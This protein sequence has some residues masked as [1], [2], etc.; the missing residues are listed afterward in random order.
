MSSLAHQSVQGCLRRLYPYMQEIEYPFLNSILL[1]LQVYGEH[2]IL[3]SIKS[4]QIRPDTLT[5]LISLA[6]PIKLTLIHVQSDI[7]H[8]DNLTRSQIP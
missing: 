6:L 5:P 7:C 1:P 4:L 8:Q 3:M 2:G